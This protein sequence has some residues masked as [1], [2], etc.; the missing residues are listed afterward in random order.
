MDVT[1]RIECGKDNIGVVDK[2]LIECFGV[3]IFNLL[4][5]VGNCLI[6]EYAGGDKLFLPIENLNVLSKYGQE[7]GEL[8]KLGSLAWQNKRSNAKKRIKEMA[9]A[10]I[11]VAAKRYLNK[12]T[13]H[14]GNINTTFYQ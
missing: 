4:D 7:F 13:I 14:K 12:G 9:H 6:I 3:W 1:K 8:D 10:L 5:V 2:I 11:A